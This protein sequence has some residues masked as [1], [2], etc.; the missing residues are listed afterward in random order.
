MGRRSL[1][2]PWSLSP[3]LLGDKWPFGGG[4]AWEE[5]KVPDLEV[6]PI[7]FGTTQIVRGMD[8]VPG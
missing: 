2:C 7:P 1:S 4:W 6:N 5:T 8:F 3:L